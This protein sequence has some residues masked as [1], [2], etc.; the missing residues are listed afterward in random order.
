MKTVCVL[1]V[2]CPSIDH[3]TP[4]CSPSLGLIMIMDTSSQCFTIIISEL[5]I[6]PQVVTM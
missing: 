4:A 3:V 1:I 2:N 6:T 5:Y